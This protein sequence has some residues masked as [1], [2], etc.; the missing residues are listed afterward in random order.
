MSG[1]R[2]TNLHK[3]HRER[4]RGMVEKNGFS[5]MPDHMILEYL[6]FYT[7][8]R[9]DTNPLAHRLIDRFGSISGVI[10]ADE[11]ELMSVKGVGKSTALFFKSIPML[12]ERYNA[13][14]GKERVDFSSVDKAGEFLVEYYRSK[15]EEE[16]TALFLDNSGC[17]ISFDVLFKGTV[18]SS[19][20]TPRKI[21][22]L[23]F[24]RRA[25]SLILAHNHPSGKAEPSDEDLSGTRRILDSFIGLDLSVIA[26][27]VVAGDRYRDILPDL[28]DKIRFSPKYIVVESTKPD[29]K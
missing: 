6:L 11:E 27:I 3:G 4:L 16:V 23:A 21:A 10:D 20:F 8:P 18:N 24:K 9:T 7:I 22:E 1:K 14:K 25:S 19:P 13:D 5:G 15:T 12:I 29:V 28:Y 2:E 26:H 17:L